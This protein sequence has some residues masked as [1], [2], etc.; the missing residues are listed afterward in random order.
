MYKYFIASIETQNKHHVLEHTPLVF[1]AE[2][3][4]KAEE[5]VEN[6]LNTLYPVKDG[7]NKNNR[8][9]VIEETSP[10][11]DMIKGLNYQPG[12]QVYACSLAAMQGEGPDAILGQMIFVVSGQTERIALTRSILRI[13]KNFPTKEGWGVQSANLAPMLTAS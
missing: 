2:N 6:E 8:F 1:F 9:S 10:F 13:N 11:V 12:E 5:R 7:Y 3:W 4:S